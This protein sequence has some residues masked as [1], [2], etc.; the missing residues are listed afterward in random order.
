MNRC[1][2]IL[3]PT[4][5]NSRKMYNIKCFSLNLLLGTIIGELYFYNNLKINIEICWNNLSLL[6]MYYCGRYTAL[7]TA[8]ENR[9]VGGNFTTI[10]QY[11]YMANMLLQLYGITWSQHCGGTLITS[12]TVLSNAYC[13]AHYSNMYVSIHYFWK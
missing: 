13:Y 8:Q 2:R 10:E 4:F 7:S 9:I 5:C 1:F 11:P 12:R 3:V 6:I